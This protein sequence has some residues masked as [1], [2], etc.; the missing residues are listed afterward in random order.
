MANSKAEILLAFGGKGGISYGGTW[1][2]SKKHVAL[3]HHG[4]HLPTAG[5]ANHWRWRDWRDWHWWQ[6]TA[7][8]WST[9]DCSHGELHM[10]M[11]VNTNLTVIHQGWPSS[12]CCSESM[13][14]SVTK[15]AHRETPRSFL[16]QVR[17]DL[18]SSGVFSILRCF[19]A[20]C[21]WGVFSWALMQQAENLST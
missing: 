17:G 3:C 11:L 16:Q 2:H 10:P 20:P 14:K 4:L 13:G 5:T 1:V 7:S 15:P 19:F 6:P 18:L 21:S 12:Y 9:T 8:W